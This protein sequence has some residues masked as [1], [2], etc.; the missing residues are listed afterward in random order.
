MRGWE[1]IIHANG[2]G[3]KAGVAILR[4]NRHQSEGQKEG[5]CLT[6]KGSMQEE[7]VTAFNTYATNIGAP[8]YIRQILTGKK[9]E[10][11]GNTTIAGDFNTPLTSVDRSSRQKIEKASEIL[12]DAIER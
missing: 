8:R 7:D 3:R 10:M 1:K 9:G 6:I 5:H 12:S 2:Q 11:D 4:Q